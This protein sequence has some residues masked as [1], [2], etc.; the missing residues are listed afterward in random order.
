VA[1]SKLTLNVPDELVVGKEF[2]FSCV[3]SDAKPPS[4]F[5][6]SKLII[7]IL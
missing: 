6:Y 7:N 4:S 1:A 5:E 3:S 2:N